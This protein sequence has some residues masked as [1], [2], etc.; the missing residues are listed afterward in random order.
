MTTKIIFL[1]IFFAIM[2]GVGIY[3][4]RHAIIGSLLAW[5]LL[6]RRTRVMTN[7]L[8]AATMPD[9]FGKRYQSNALRIAASAIAFIFMIPYTA[10]VYNGLSR[11][12]LSTSPHQPA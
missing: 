12:F 3:S 4:K 11:L 5:V 2:I 1:V 10:S 9:Y 8:K 6:G 7:H